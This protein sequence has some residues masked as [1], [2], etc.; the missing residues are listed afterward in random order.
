MD[1]LRLEVAEFVD[2]DHWRWLLTDRSGNFVADHQVA[3]DRTDPEYVAFADLAAYLRREAVPD[4]RL[5]SEAELVARV[6][7]WI[8]RQVLGEAGRTRPWSTPARWW[9]G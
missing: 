8:G 2:A 3:L 9:Y 4:R 7:G 6:G 1:T 5:A